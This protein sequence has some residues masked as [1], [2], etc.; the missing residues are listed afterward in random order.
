MIQ[1]GTYREQLVEQILSLARDGENSPE[2]IKAVRVAS[3]VKHVAANT[4]ATFDSDQFE[5]WLSDRSA[6][7]VI[8]IYEV[9]QQTGL[10]FHWTGAKLSL[11]CEAPQNLQT[12]WTYDTVVGVAVKRIHSLLGLT[13]KDYPERWVQNAMDFLYDC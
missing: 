13:P 8:V 7:E 2:H 5:E 6:F 11:H 12:R 4:T 3:I 9:M 1:L 10:T